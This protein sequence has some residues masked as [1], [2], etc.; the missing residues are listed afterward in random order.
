MAA[1]KPPL[2]QRRRAVTAADIENAR[3]SVA[4]LPRT[5]RNFIG[6]CGIRILVHSAEERSE[7]IDQRR[8]ARRAESVI[9]I[10]HRHIRRAGVQHA[11]QRGHSAQ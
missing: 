3:R 9:D 5:E 10:H 4:S 1:G 6:Q 8:D 11:Q 2:G 7:M